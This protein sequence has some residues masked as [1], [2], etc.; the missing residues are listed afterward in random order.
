MPLA[1]RTAERLWQL[2]QAPERKTKQ[3]A[4]Y[5]VPAVHSWRF[6]IQL[7]EA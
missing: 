4:M 7:L 1:A 3:E 6:L 5:R 2:S